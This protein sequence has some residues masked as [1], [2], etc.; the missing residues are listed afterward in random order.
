M[1]KYAVIADCHGNSWALRAVLADIERRKV[2]QIINLGDSA[3]AAMDAGGVVAIL[4]QRQIPS[5][6]GN[7]E[8]Y[9]PGQLTFEQETWLSSLPKTMEIG[10]LYCCH[11]SPASDHEE[12]LEDIALPHVGLATP[13]QILQRLCGITNPVIL[14][15]HKHVPRLVLMPTGQIIVNPGSVGWPAYWNDEPALH[16]METGSPHARYALLEQTADGWLVDHIAVPYDWETAAEFA[17]QR[18]HA[19]RAT[20]LRT[21]RMTA[22]DGAGKE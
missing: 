17:A 10:E 1:E 19:L 3:D 2:K 18:G 12:L 7:Y 22:P 6:A 14:C 9:E 21:G 15:A 8:T 20:A 13:E 5:L 4:L 11:G 16:V